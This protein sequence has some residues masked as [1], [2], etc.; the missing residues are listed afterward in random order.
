[1]SRTTVY[2]P[3]SATDE[4]SDAVVAR[5]H[6]LEVRIINH[7]ENPIYYR[8]GANATAD[9]NSEV[10]GSGFVDDLDMPTDERLS[11][12]CAEGLTASVLIKEVIGPK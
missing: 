10:L 11:I 5:A 12:C 8:W 7:G 6:R 4:A 9:A 1:M 2:T 3:A